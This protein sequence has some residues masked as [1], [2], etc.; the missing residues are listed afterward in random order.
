ML[1]LSLRVP[2]KNPIVHSFFYLLFV[3]NEREKGGD[4]NKRARIFSFVFN[5][6]RIQRRETR[7]S[8]VSALVPS[9][10]LF[11]RARR[12]R[13]CIVVKTSRWT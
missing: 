10:F 11:N 1:S 5:K 8:T 2:Y 7:R 3:F 12:E 9:R 6:E 4:R 13:L